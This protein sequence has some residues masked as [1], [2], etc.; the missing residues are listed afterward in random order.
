MRM[1][2]RVH[3]CVCAPVCAY[4]RTSR[5]SE[6]EGRQPSLGVECGSVGVRGSA[7]GYGGG[8]GG[9]GQGGL[10]LLIAGEGRRA[11]GTAS[12]A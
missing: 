4:V 9:G 5:V 11:R 6:E 3:V 7:G 2:E 8:G 12:H 1:Y 10:D